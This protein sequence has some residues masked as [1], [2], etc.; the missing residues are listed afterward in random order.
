MSGNFHLTRMRSRRVN[1]FI[2]RDR[3]SFQSFERHRAGNIGQPRQSFG[4]IQRQPADSTHRLRSVQQR[5]AFLDFQLNGCDPARRKRFG[6]RQSFALV[7][8]F[9]FADR[10]EREMGQAAPDHRWLRPIPSP[11]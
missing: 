11:E 5:Q 6:A 10:R 1:A 2:K 3:R 4:A 8:R 9:A 7:E